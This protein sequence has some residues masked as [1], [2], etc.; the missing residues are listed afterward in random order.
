MFVPV[1]CAPCGK[2][3]QVPEPTLGQLTVCPWCQ[4][5]VLALPLGGSTPSALPANPPPNPTETQPDATSAG[6]ADQNKRT[7]LEPLSLDDPAPPAAVAR[8]WSPFG[9]SHHGCVLLV[10][11]SLIIV[12]TLIT[13]FILRYK[14]S[15]V[16]ALEWQPFTPPDHSFSIDLLGKAN[17]QEIP[18]DRGEARYVSEGPYSGTMSWIGWRSLTAAQAQEATAEQ[19]WVQLKKVIFDP[20]RERLQT[21]FGATLTREATIEQKP[22]TVEVRLDGARGRLIE[23]MIVLSNGPRPRV[24]LIGMMGKRLNLDGPE[25]ERFFKSF[26]VYD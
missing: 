18:H 10:G 19:G 6:A 16:L 1:T 22:L 7:L 4:A 20:E 12:P 23:R 13:F 3:F 21:T 26:Q 25:V 24:Y 14:Q 5:T 8:W 9:I 17:E 11:L 15:Q 2:P